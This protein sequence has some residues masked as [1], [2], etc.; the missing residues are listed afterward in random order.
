[1]TARESIKFGIERLKAHGITSM[2]S[3]WGNEEIFDD[4]PVPSDESLY[5]EFCDELGFNKDE[6]L[7]FLVNRM[8]EMEGASC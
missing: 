5:N 7:V 6:Y 4:F 2:D 3:V 8:E 1:M